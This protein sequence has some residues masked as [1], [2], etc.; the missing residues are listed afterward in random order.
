MK[1]K[2]VYLGKSI[3]SLVVFVVLLILLLKNH[4]VLSTLIILPFLFCSL[5]SIGKNLSFIFGKKKLA[6]VFG[7]LFVICFLVL[8]FGFLIYGSVLLI[9]GG[10]YFSLLFTLP[11]WLA[12]IYIVYK[13][14]FHKGKKE[15]SK[16]K[17]PKLSFQIV[18]T[19]FLVLVVLIIG[20]VC[21]IFGIRD[22]YQFNKI[23]KNYVETDG[24]FVDYN[25]Y[26]V[27]EDG[28]TYQLVYTYE[29]EG[30]QYKTATDYGV[31]SIPE[32][33]SV[34][35]VKYNPNNPS[36]AVLS[37]TNRSNFLIFFGAFFTLGGMVFALGALHIKGVFDGFRFDV[38]GT[39]LGF[40][41]LIIGIGIILLQLG[42]V[43]SLIEV[44]QSFGFWIFVPIMF[45]IIGVFQIVKCLFVKRKS[46][47]YSPS[48]SDT[49]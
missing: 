21:L 30:N 22:R 41:F 18:V 45:I 5:F 19:S 31:G 46:N 4:S 6:A 29:V 40:V 17:A 44:I 2:N 14:L 48:D 15:K 38:I 26:D 42:T 11:F 10:N 49:D 1:S 47:C 8:W 34:R 32:I 20:T 27:D 25:I 37:G 3:S 23:T 33:N 35:K 24:Y 7:K 28:T 39:F 13:F 12:G 43:S 36:E 9:K 16:K